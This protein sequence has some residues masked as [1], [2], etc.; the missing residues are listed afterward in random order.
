MENP[1]EVLAETHRRLRVEASSNQMINE[2]LMRIEGYPSVRSLN[3]I[4]VLPPPVLIERY[5]LGSRSV[6]IISV[7]SH[8]ASPGELELEQLRFESFVPADETSAGNSSESCVLGKRQS[9]PLG[10]R[11]P[12]QRQT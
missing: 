1:V 11:F 9:K 4:E 6:S 7:I 8:L 3:V 2:T 10:V 12:P 5:K